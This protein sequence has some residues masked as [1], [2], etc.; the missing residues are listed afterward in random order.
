MIRRAI[1]LFTLAA[2]LSGCTYFGS[3]FQVDELNKAQAKGA[4]FTQ[5]LTQQYKDRANYSQNVTYNYDE[6][7]RNADKGLTAADGTPVAPYS[8]TDFNVP[9]SQKQ[10][11]IKARIDLDK[12]LNSGARDRAPKE[13]ALAQ[14]KFDCWVEDAEKTWMPEL[15]KT[16]RK[17][18]YNAFQQMMA[19]QGEPVDLSGVDLNA[20]TT[21]NAEANRF[22]IFFGAGGSKLS[23]TVAPTLDQIAQ[24]ILQR[25]P[26]SIRI[27]G[28][29]DRTGGKKSRRTISQR[30][31]IAVAEALIVRG[32]PQKVI[33]TH[34]LGDAQPLVK[35]K[36]K[37]VP[38]NRRAEI[39]LDQSAE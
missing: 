28:F 39:W 25:Q 18:F 16:C 5:A 21:V 36:S 37:N 27:N 33:H 7:Y 17:E 11:V 29:S 20:S 8:L 31:A 24:I 6:A 23:P 15:Y 22:M 30:R 9:E 26:P 12:A 10:E 3:Y 34:G 38:A 13:A 2:S 32:V 19:M 4:P 35:T 14:A 1:A